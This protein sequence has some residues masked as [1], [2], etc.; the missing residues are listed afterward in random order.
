MLSTFPTWNEDLDKDVQYGI[1]LVA[2]TLVGLANPLAFSLPTKVSNDWFP[3]VEAP[4][5][6]GFIIMSFLLGMVVGVG[7]T[8]IIFSDEDLIQWMNIA[9]SVPS[10]VSFVCSI[11]LI[12]SDQPPSP[13]SKSTLIKNKLDIPYLK[14]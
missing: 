11:T 5:A 13:P 9:W 8:P 1:T 7:F 2:Q 10:M 14:K 6:S 12:T 4:M 3:E